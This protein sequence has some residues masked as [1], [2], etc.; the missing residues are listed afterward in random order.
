MSKKYSIFDVVKDV[1][2]GNVN[3]SSGDLASKRIAICEECP[4]L[5]KTFKICGK[6]GCQMDA[7]VRFTKASCPIGKW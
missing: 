6:C 4:E 3:L 5:K 7:K 2:T 1:A